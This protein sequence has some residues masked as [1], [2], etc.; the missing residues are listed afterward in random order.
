MLLVA[1]T[2]SI[3]RTRGSCHGP[4][5]ATAVEDIPPWRVLTADRGGAAHASRML[6]LRADGRFA[7][8]GLSLGGGI[9]RLAVRPEARAPRQPP[10]LVW[11]ADTGPQASRCADRRT[12][13][14]P[15]EL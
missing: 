8:L 6:S 10:R 14:R 2:T 5:L 4:Q 11:G 12:R 9:R 13:P 3:F 1:S 7:R 15:S